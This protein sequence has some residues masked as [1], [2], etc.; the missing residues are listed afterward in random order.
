MISLRPLLP[1]LPKGMAADT[2]AP[3]RNLD[4]LALLWVGC[5]CLVLT[6]LALLLPTAS[7]ADAFTDNSGT[8]FILSASP[9]SLPVGLFGN[10]Y[11]N[12]RAFNTYVYCAQSCRSVSISR[13][14]LVF[15]PED[16]GTNG[17]K[18]VWSVQGGARACQQQRGRGAPPA[19]PLPWPSAPCLP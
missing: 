14:P 2:S 17:F 18:V 7:T 8:L 6:S 9:S 12:S 15:S 11:I 19:P 16:S 13:D 5:F 10:V 3:A 4:L 1:L